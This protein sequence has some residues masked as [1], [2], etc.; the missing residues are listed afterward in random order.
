MGFSV[1]G[2]SVVAIGAMGLSGCSKKDESK[3][4]PAAEPAPVPERAAAEPPA[5]PLALGHRFPVGPRLVFVPG[6][7][8]GAIRFG[9][10]VETIERHMEGPC[11]Q[12][13]EERCLYVRQ[14]LE[15]FLKDGELVRI[16]AHR[17]DHRVDG[18]PEK[19]DQYF[20]S[21]RGVLPPKVMM[22]LHRHVV[23][24]EYGKPDKK[25]PINPPGPDGQ[26]ERHF[27]DGVIL[28]Y[29]KIENGNTVLGAIEIYP[30]KTAKSHGKIVRPTGAGPSP[31]PD[32]HR[33][34]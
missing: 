18:A 34:K 6:K 17:R 32:V 10:T 15:F 7:G 31:S 22:G 2:F 28:E 19:G 33:A 30:S 8:V 11:D 26:V 24:E 21:L 12:K 16:R 25:E 1:V 5:R 13:T 3:P 9:A 29:D 4:A 27:Y 14:A 23:V 20:G